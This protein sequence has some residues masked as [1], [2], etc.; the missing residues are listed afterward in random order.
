VSL[1]SV[2]TSQALEEALKDLARQGTLVKDRPQRQVWRFEAGV[3][4][5]YLKF[6]PR[7]GGALKRLVR[8]NPALREFVRLQWLQKAGVPAPKGIAMLAGFAIGGKRGDA[9]VM[10]AVEPAIAVD[11]LLNETELNDGDRADHFRISQSIRALVKQMAKAGLGHSDLHLGNFLWKDD[12]VYLLD[13]YAVHKNGLRLKDLLLL[14]H[15]VNRYATK[16]DLVRAW[17]ELGTGKA[18]AINALSGPMWKKFVGRATG[19]N[20]YFGRVRDKEW[21]GSFFR[22]FKYPRPWS[23]VSAM[24]V[25]GK[26]WERAW[27]LLQGQ[28]ESDQLEVLKR[29]ASGDVLA[30]EVVLNGHPVGVIVKRPRQKHWRR[31]VQQLFRGSRARQAW[32]KAWSLVVRDIPTAWP[33][34]LMEKRVL[35]YVTDSVIVFEKIEGVNLALADLDTMGD[36]ERRSFFHRCGRLLRKLEA[37]GLYHW[38]AKASNFMVARDVKGKATPVLVDVDGIRAIQWTR[39]SIER[40]LRSLREHK[41]YTPEDS[42]WLCRGYAP[43][44]RIEREKE[45]D[46]KVTR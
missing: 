25:D 16:G 46:D 38:D 45:E 23:R 36:E 39:S 20:D 4:G 14:G 13:A 43:F 32:S 15:S 34:L 9:V 12:R 17:E 28:M 10:E 18:P 21:R 41:Q 8:G 3:Q 44:A 5:Y 27:P 35:G 11:R 33:I 2:L 1:K 7:R 40:L 29:S 37:D 26:A 6:Y 24:R 19:E 31:Y 30:G 42:F 22:W